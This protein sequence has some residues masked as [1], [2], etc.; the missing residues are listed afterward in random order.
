L[1]PA[2]VAAEV[3]AVSGPQDNPTMALQVITEPHLAEM[4]KAEAAAMAPAGVV[5]VVV[6]MAELV[7]DCLAATTVDFLEK[8]ALV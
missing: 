8:T 1:L 4:V 5:A 7:V 3:A 6:K 2:E